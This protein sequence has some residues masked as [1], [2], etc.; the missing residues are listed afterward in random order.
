M[1]VCGG[2]DNKSRKK[3]PQQHQILQLANESEELFLE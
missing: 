1:C 3:N 2:G